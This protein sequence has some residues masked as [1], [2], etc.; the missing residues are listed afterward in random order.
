MWVVEV[1]PTTGLQ[2]VTVIGLEL[3]LKVLAATVSASR[4]GGLGICY[5]HSSVSEACKINIF[6]RPT[7][8]FP[9]LFYFS[10]PFSCSRA[11]A[12]KAAGHI[13]HCQLSAPKPAGVMA[14]ATGAM[15]GCVERKRAKG[16][17]RSKKMVNFA[18]RMGATPPPYRHTDT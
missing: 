12:R 16:V 17:D 6:S 11:R 15:W 10:P 8:T 1:Q 3:V 14:G 18:G 5:Y 13:T 7:R 4:T 9:A 2:S